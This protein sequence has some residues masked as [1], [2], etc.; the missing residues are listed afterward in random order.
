MTC[1]DDHMFAFCIQYSILLVMYN[2]KYIN[3]V[4]TCM[5]VTEI[6]KSLPSRLGYVDTKICDKQIVLKTYLMCIRRRSVGVR[7]SSG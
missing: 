4:D 6:G 2:G 7:L 5:S 1:Y 3:I